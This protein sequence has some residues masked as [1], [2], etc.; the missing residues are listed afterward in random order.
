[1]AVPPWALRPSLR[2]T[3]L[4]PASARMVATAATIPMRS[5]LC[6]ISI[7]RASGSSMSWS[8]TITTLGSPSPNIVPAT[9]WRP[10]R[11]ADQVGVAGSA[12]AG[13]DCGAHLQAA[14]VGQLRG[15]DVGD[16]LV[17]GHREQ[18]LEHGQRQDPGVVIGQAA[19]ELDVERGR[20]LPGQGGPEPAQAL[21][22][23][24]PRPNRLG[25]LGRG[26]V[27]REG[28]ELPG[29]RQ[30][31]LLGDRHPGL[32]L[33][34]PGAGPQVGRHHHLVELEERR[35]RDRLV[36]EHVQGG[37]GHDPVRNRLGQ[38]L[39]VD[40]PTAGGVD[41]SNAG[42][43]PGQKIGTDAARWFPGSSGRWM[44]RKSASATTRSRGSSS[45]PSCRARS[46]LT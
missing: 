12:L 44:V 46:A 36:L 31:H 35:G 29:Q 8:S 2:S 15:V 23:R 14:L 19:L 6:T 13:R 42:L 22:Q 34:L 45:A 41:D 24:Q 27:D 4:H 28:H 11:S 5:S 20:K 16:G 33:G 39:L 7:Q 18:A 37:P 25:N 21:G 17:S 30:L 32:V 1:M 40:D 38:S 26:D 10:P 9:A 3:M 43:G